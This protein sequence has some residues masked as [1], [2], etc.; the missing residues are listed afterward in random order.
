MALLHSPSLVELKQR[1]CVVLF[2]GIVCLLVMGCAASSSSNPHRNGS[3]GRLETTMLTSV[4]LVRMTDAM[5]RSLVASGIDFQYRENSAPD[6]RFII[7]TYRVVNRTNHI[8][9]AGE[10]ELFL[11]RLRTLLNQQGVLRAEGV[12]FVARPDELSVYSE[13][14]GDAESKNSTGPTHALTATF[15]TLT[16]VD[17][18]HRADSYECA[19]QLQELKT[20]QI[21]WEDAYTV[22]YSTG[23]GKMW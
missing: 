5:A 17:R 16:N 11:N 10:K 21:V 19:F 15:A 14:M 13:P 6:N 20:R 8:I 3:G 18:Q 9:E 22:E 1:G 4:D 23:R 2:A 12:V 7:V